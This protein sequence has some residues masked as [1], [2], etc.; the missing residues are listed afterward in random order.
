MGNMSLTEKALN[1]QLTETSDDFLLECYLLSINAGEI[2]ADPY[3]KAVVLELQEVFD[4]LLRVTP[5]PPK[6]RKRFSRFISLAADK[7]PSAPA[8]KG[9]YLWGGVGR[10]KTHL[11]DYFYKLLPTEKKLRLHFH[12]FMEL[13]HEEL[14]E[15]DGIPD[16]L[17]VVAK[18]F[19]GKT[20][21]LCLDEM[22]V[23]DI[24]DAMLLGKLFEHLFTLGVV[25][26]TT[27]N[28][29]PDQLYKNGLQ[30]DRF[31]PAIKLLENHT[32]VVKMEGDE[33][34]RQKSLESNAVY[35]LSSGDFEASISE[36]RLDNYFH[37]LS[38][39]ELHQDRTDIIISDRKIPVKKWADGVVWF[40]FD[41]LCNTPRSA[42]DY[43][44]IAKYFHTVLISDIPVMDSSMDD[45]VR[46][47][48][49][50]IDTLYDMHTNIVISAFSEPEFLYTG[51]KLAFEFQRTASRLREM[52]SEEYTKIRYFS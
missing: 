25:L 39:T 16:P 15:L 50:L 31:E 7:Q 8:I 11:V 48:V 37:K 6:N 20:Q 24:T 23:N 1:E 33:D 32:K 42:S 2:T 49:N 29:P 36:Q 43:C 45:V 34:Y 10:G 51:K 44:H 41:E 35:Y 4:S 28:I 26:V 52:Q 46:R 22:H 14:N 13:V 3:Q 17:E 12:R 27:S 30:R 19:A 21:L 18:S 38:G 9:L 5:T 40:D 47:F